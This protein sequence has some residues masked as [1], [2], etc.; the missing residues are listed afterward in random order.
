MWNPFRK[1]STLEKTVEDPSRALK[2]GLAAVT[3]LV[4]VAVVG[5]VV[6]KALNGDDES[7]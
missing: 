1:K 2:S 7:E 6:S 5:A 3:I 4:G